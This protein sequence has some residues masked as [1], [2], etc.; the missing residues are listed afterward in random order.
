[1]DLRGITLGKHYIVAR[2]NFEGVVNELRHEY[3]K[4]PGATSGGIET[5]LAA[6]LKAARNILV[7]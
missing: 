6:D 3:K 1:M 5:K 4:A 2:Q 7:R